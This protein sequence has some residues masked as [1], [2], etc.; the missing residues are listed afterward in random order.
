MATVAI[1]ALLPVIV[2]GH[3]FTG[4]AERPAGLS[5]PAGADPQTRR[6]AAAPPPSL[7]VQFHGMWST[8]NDAE[9]AHALDQMR[10]MGAE[11]VRIDVGWSMIQPTRRG[12]Y[13]LRWGVPFVD[14]VIRQAHS[15][16]FKVLVMFWLTPGWA[17]GNRGARVAPTHPEDYANAAA[18]AVKRWG[19]K[20]SAWEVWNEPNSDD[21]LVGASPTQYTDLLCAAD[22][23]M[24]RAQ[25]SVKVVY[26]GTMHNDDA[27]IARTYKA[28]VKG[29][30]D[31]LATHPYTGPSDAG[32]R[33]PSDGDSWEFRNIESVRQ[34]QLRHNDAKPIWLT[35]FGW[36]SHPND[37]SEAP[38]EVGVTQERQGELAVRALEVVR[39]RYPFVNAA[40]WYNELNKSTGNEHQD[41]FGILTR[42][43]ERKPIWH[44]LRTYLD[45]HGS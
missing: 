18:W 26:G 42:S 21:F 35:E 20:V 43:G 30:F 1:V 8:Y 19:S 40:F 33:A 10:S 2:P 6:A 38:W 27:W 13:D 22:R 24:H 9:R 31:I 7:G 15:R 25:E 44:R 28:G 36:S 12:E 34:L 14:R 11:W 37:G 29:C 16:G 39:K 17:N 32:P 23:A 3:A 41:N 4:T 5:A 45:Q